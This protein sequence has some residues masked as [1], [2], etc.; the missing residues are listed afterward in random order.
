M[1]PSGVLAYVVMAN[2]VMAYTVMSLVVLSLWAAQA[3]SAGV[4]DDDLFEAVAAVV[5]RT[6][7]KARAVMSF[8]LYFLWCRKL[9]P[10]ELPCLGHSRRRGR[11]L[12]MASIVMAY[13]V[14][15]YRAAVLRTLPKAWAVISYSPYCYGLYSRGL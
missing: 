11:R 6:L 3:C 1:G 12:V 8:G 2:I 5:L 9:W 10:I 13:I 4:R 14:T 15:A 7:P